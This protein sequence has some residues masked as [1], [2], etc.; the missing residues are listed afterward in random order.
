[1]FNNV[2]EGS[3]QTLVCDSTLSNNR[4]MIISLPKPFTYLF[5]QR[6]YIFIQLVGVL[7][8]LSGC[9]SFV[10]SRPALQDDTSILGAVYSLPMLQ[11]KIDIC[12]EYCFVQ[13]YCYFN[14][15]YGF[16]VVYS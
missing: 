2:L 12:K 11:F 4:S 15:N 5:P 16:R 1:M 10:N 3:T 8:L 14:G 9:S 6:G 13:S 7:F